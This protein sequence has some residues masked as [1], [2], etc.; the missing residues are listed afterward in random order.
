MGIGIGGILL[1]FHATN[2]A[3]PLDPALPSGENLETHPAI[4]KRPLGEES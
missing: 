2:R 3:V 4:R 1:R